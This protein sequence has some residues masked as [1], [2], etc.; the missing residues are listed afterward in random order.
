MAFSISELINI[1]KIVFETINSRI[2]IANEGGE[3][4]LRYYLHSINVEALNDENPAY[5]LY[6][7]KTK[8]LVFGELSGKKNE[9]IFRAKKLGLSENNLEF[10]DYNEAKKFDVAKL[11][12]S[13][14][15]SD[16]IVGPIPHKVKGLEDYS[17][18]LAQMEDH[19]EKYPKVL[20]ATANNT[21]KLSVT[22]FESCI[23]NTR[24]CQYMKN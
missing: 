4:S 24:L 3:E 9:Y 8:V 23:I 5:C 19:P 13:D 10:V 21:L 7:R 11:E 14:V 12:Y 17:S 20:K 18:F 1:K 22:S 15:Y 2:D 16:I 6:D